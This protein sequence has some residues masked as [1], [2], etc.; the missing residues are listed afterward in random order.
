[1]SNVPQTP[2]SCP[3]RFSVCSLLVFATGATAPVMLN[4]VGE[5]F[6]VELLLPMVAFALLLFVG[7]WRVLNQRPFLT[8]LAAFYVMLI[9]YVLSDI[10]T[11]SRPDQYLRGWGRV[12]LTISNF[13]SCYVL[14][15]TD[16]RLFWWLVLGMGIGGFAYL[17]FNGVPLT[18]WKIGYADPFVIVTLALSWILPGR[19]KALPILVL[20]PLNF[21]LD[22]RSF[23]AICLAIGAYVW[24][25]SG[26][27][28][29]EIINWRSTLKY[30]FFGI[31]VLGL[32]HSLLEASADKDSLDRRAQ[33]NAGRHAATEI[34]LIAISQSPIIGYGSWSEDRELARMQ[35]QL[36]EEEAGYAK[37]PSGMT[38]NGFGPHSQVLNAW[39]EGGILAASFFF[40][41]FYRI[42]V[43]GRWILLVRRSDWLSPLLAFV[44]LTTAWNALMS[45]F[46]GTHRMNIAVGAAILA[47]SEIDR[48]RSALLRRRVTVARLCDR[49]GATARASL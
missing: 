32:T 48:R 9:G 13:V 5:L 47:V 17:H 26:S 37:R 46:A 7:G 36:A 4:V 23:G 30:A 31:L 49:A 40:Y 41:L 11:G 16:R 45:P 3:F 18:R 6:M 42:L 20:G 19:I 1:M 14:F 33:S 44:L 21:W 34:G 25:A 27:T 15:A 22:F 8:M 10:V 35:R 43:T 2:H 39:V 38:G 28:G 24:L 12:L 29:R